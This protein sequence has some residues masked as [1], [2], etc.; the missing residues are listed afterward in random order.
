MQAT[1]SHSLRR[2]LALVAGPPPGNA[3]AS[4]TTM[5]HSTSKAAVQ[6]VQPGSPSVSVSLISLTSASR[7][8]L[9]TQRDTFKKV[10]LYRMR[11]L[12]GTIAVVWCLWRKAWKKDWIFAWRHTLLEWNASQ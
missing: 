9:L 2:I 11:T 10:T 3:M 5:G 12:G 8:G 1:R 4:H 7:F 6:S